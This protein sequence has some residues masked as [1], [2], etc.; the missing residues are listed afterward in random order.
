LLP[1][2]ASSPVLRKPA[3]LLQQRKL[4]NCDDQNERYAVY[5]FEMVDLTREMVLVTEKCFV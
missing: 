1:G 2:H 3:A 5:N 4:T